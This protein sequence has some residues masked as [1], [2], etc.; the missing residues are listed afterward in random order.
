MVAS[1]SLG[2]P[3]HVGTGDRFRVAMDLHFCWGL[4]LSG[5]YLP[6]PFTVCAF[7]GPASQVA[8]AA[9]GLAVGA[10]VDRAPLVARGREVVPSG[11][12]TGEVVN[13]GLPLCPDVGWRG[14]VA[15][16]R[17][18]LVPVVCNAEACASLSCAYLASL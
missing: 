10:P 14:G 7:P 11:L 4:A 1:Q 18:P 9:A 3:V 15:L 13:G 17:L 5:S 16:G 6:M 12:Q 2:L 8:L